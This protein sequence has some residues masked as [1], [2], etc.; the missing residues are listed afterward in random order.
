MAKATQ[1]VK[2]T[3]KKKSVKITPK[4]PQKRCECGRFI[5]S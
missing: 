5:K 2:S 1:T 4:K 3:N